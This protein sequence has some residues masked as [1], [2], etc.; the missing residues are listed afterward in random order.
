MT[1]KPL[2]QLEKTE[3]GLCDEIYKAMDGLTKDQIKYIRR[4][5]FHR[6]SS[7]QGSSLRAAFFDLFPQ[8][9][10]KI[11][12]LDPNSNEGRNVIT[13]LQ[14]SLEAKINQ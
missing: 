10:E 4:L 8:I 13:H 6:G 3:A 14:K 5:S 12:S 11:N 9:E 2:E 7:R 1:D